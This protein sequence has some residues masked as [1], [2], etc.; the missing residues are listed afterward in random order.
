M[1]TNVNIFSHIACLDLAPGPEA[2]RFRGVLG[3][4]LC[5]FP[6][7]LF[8]SKITRKLISI[9]LSVNCFQRGSFI[10]FHVE[11]GACY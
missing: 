11:N 5:P 3:Y 8:V 10:F 6:L 4:L 9:F 2:W 7:G 1:A